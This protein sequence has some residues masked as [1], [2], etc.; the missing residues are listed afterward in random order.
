M[1]QFFPSA[2]TGRVAL[3]F[4]SAIFIASDIGCARFSRGDSEPKSLSEAKGQDANWKI[5]INT[6][7]ASELE[8]LP[9]IGEVIAKRIVSHRQQHGPFRRAEHLMM[10]QGISEKKFRDIQ[11]LVTVD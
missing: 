3:L 10:V 6:A 4:L 9:G 5:N 8:K 2:K 7:S 1:K 11:S